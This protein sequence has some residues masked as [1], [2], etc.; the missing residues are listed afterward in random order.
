MDIF[1]L[2]RFGLVVPPENPIAEPEYHSY[3]VPEM[4]VYTTRFPVTAEFNRE[5]MEMY[6]EVLAQ[7]LA[8]FGQL[9][10]D[11][12]VVACNASHYLLDPDGDRDFVAELSQRFGSPVTSSTRA[13]VDLCEAL[14]TSNLTLISPYAPWLTE[15]SR[16]YWEKAGL[17]VERIV[18]TPS[19]VDEAGQDVGFNPYLVTTETIRQRIAEAEV[20][21]DATVLFTGT[22]MHTLRAATEL[23]GANPSRTLITS[24]L[25]SA[26]WARRTAGLSG[27]AAAHPLVQRLERELAAR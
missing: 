17:T 19:A 7:V 3:L 27:F 13:I 21:D 5:T 26:W 23:A 25:A 20:A 10:L 9:R 22:G 1:P 8:T 12:T 11:A 2:P 16:D 18:C 15:L 24:N 6:N 14:G 4:N